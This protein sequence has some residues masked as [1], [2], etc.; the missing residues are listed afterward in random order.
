MT[1]S[2]LDHIISI[3]NRKDLNPKIEATVLQTNISVH[4][5]TILHIEIK[6]KKGKLSKIVLK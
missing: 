3:K 4:F 2:Y 5:P 1:C 6:I